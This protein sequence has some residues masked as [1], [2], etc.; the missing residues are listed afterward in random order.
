MEDTKKHDHK[1]QRQKGS[2]HD[3]IWN[4]KHTFRLLIQRVSFLFFV[5]IVLTCLFYADID[6]TLLLCSMLMWLFTRARQYYCC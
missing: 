1:D 3:E 2:D 6:L 5:M 4:E